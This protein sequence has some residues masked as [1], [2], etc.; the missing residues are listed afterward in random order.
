MIKHL[1]NTVGAGKQGV[2]GAR[3]FDTYK[4]IF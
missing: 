4:K 1:L 2:P 3:E